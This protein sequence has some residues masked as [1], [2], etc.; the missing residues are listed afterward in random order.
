M[1]L[2]ALS[3]KKYYYLQ[4]PGLIETVF[5]CLKNLC[6]LDHTRHRSPVNFFVNIWSA[7]LAYTYF[8][9]FP[10]ITPFRERIEQNCQFVFI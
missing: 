7:L 4:H 9:E 3:A 8:D 10:A 5:D 2:Q 6:N 1:G